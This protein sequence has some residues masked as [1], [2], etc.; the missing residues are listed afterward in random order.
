[1][2]RYIKSTQAIFAGYSCNGW[3]NILKT[4]KIPEYLKWDSLEKREWDWS[5]N[6]NHPKY[7]PGGYDAV[8]RYTG[9]AHSDINNYL[10]GR[11]YKD[12]WVESSPE[13]SSEQIHEVISKF[14]T[15]KDIVTIRHSNIENLEAYFGAGAAENIADGDFSD[16]VGQVVTERGFCSTSM[17][18]AL[19]HVGFDKPV[20]FIILLP[21][22][23]SAIYIFDVTSHHEH[24]FE[25][26]LQNNTSFIIRDIQYS[27]NGFNSA[28]GL[29]SNAKYRIFMEKI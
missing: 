14:T 2:K 10:R 27:G 11:P 25:V 12:N 17:S 26:L 19:D 23:T 15:P 7:T 3:F 13:E 29:A 8:R 18:K 28:S 21:K 5:Y 22:G 6:E 4:Q 1:M 20:E 16:Y 24:E 9:K